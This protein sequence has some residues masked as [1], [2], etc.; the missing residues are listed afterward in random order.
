MVHALQPVSSSSADLICGLNGHD[1]FFYLNYV[2]NLRR[3]VGFG[4][5]NFSILLQN[6]P[7]YANHFVGNMKFYFS[8]ISNNDKGLER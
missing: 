6:Y 8:H 7:I 3:N 4:L 5:H 1:S 2:T